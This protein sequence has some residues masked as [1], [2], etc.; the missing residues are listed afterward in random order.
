PPGG[1]HAPDGLPA[2]PEGEGAAEEVT[3][4]ASGRVY[5]GRAF[6]TA[7]VNPAARQNS[8]ISLLRAAKRGTSGVDDPA[9]PAAEQ[10][11]H[12]GRSPRTHANI[13]GPPD[14][15]LPAAPAARASHRRPRRGAAAF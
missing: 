12:A 15:V 10:P 4:R 1:L 3:A 6:K 9:R 14:A 13:P 8:H 5:P 11:A 2:R 7:G